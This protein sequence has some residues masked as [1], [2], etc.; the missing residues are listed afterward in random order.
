MKNLRLQLLVSHLLALVIMLVVMVG[1]VYSFFHLGMSIERIVKDN[2]QSVEAVQNMKE[3]LERMDSAATFHLAGEPARAREQYRVHAR[4]FR[5]AH[6]AQANNITEHGEQELSDRLDG[7]FA[8]YATDMRRFLS[9]DPT[10]APAAARSRYVNALEPAFETLKD[11][12]QRILALNQSAI[13]RAN[14][15]AKA[16]AQRASWVAVVATLGAFVVAI[17]VAVRMVGI[18]L[19]PL[20]VLAR[21]AEEIGSGKLDQQIATGRS[22]EVGVLAGA[23][24]R[25]A[26]QLR[27][28][29]DV[30]ERRLHLAERMSDQALQS[31]YDPVI[32][33]DSVGKVVH[34]NRAAEELFGAAEISKGA[35]AC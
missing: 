22:D 20:P 6:A 35:D 4:R 21:Q 18:A 8:T 31:L 15:R 26:E 34:L 14:A 1:A 16:E 13:L 5:E 2:Y 7:L 24:S 3:A 25:M 27:H 23:L 12:A 29:R 33:T 17:L 30:E 9:A 19:S 10:A 11:H 32:V 28:A